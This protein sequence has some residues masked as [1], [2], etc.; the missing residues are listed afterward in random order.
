MHHVCSRQRI[1]GK[2]ALAMQLIEQCLELIIRDFVTS[3]WCHGCHGRGSTDAVGGELTF[4]VQLIKQRFEFSVSDF[5]AGLGGSLHLCFSFGLDRIERVKQLLEFGVGNVC[6]RRLFLH[7][8][9]RGGRFGSRRLSQTRQGCQQLRRG[10][11]D[12]TAFAHLAEHAVDRVQCFQDHV[13]Q[14]GINAPLTLAQDVE[15]VFGD[16]AALHQLVELEEAGAP[17]Y[18]VKTAKD[19]IEQIGIIR[20]AFQLDQLLGQLL[21]N[22][23]GFYQKILKDFFIGAEAH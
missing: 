6:L 23:A 3:S 11:G 19:R 15:D 14:L 2:V 22:L 1:N 9:R 8:L 7:R 13:H 20:T 5:V 12:I 10:R 16:V 17:F 4:T 21:K 18:S